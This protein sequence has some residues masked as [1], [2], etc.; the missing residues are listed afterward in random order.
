LF[1]SATEDAKKPEDETSG[2]NLELPSA[3]LLVVTLLLGTFF[4][5]SGGRSPDEASET[6]KLAEGVYARIVRPDGPAV[7]NAGFIVL[8][9]GVLVYDTHATPE[10]GQT[11]LSA[12]AA[13]TA[14]PVRYIVNS[15]FHP[16][17][18]HGNQAFG[19]S[20]LVVGGTN[21]RRD[22]LQKDVPAM[23]RSLNIAQ[24]QL[25]RMRRELVRERDRDQQA[26]LRNQIR[27][28]QE[29]VDRMSKIKVIPPILTLDDRL[30]LKDAAREIQV[31]QLGNGH[32]DGDVILF[33]AREK[34]AFL[35]DLFFNRA[36]PNTQDS[37]LLPWIA[38]LGAILKL[39]ADVFVPGHGP[40][41]NRDQ[42]KQFL[43]Y[44]EDLKASVEPRVSRGDSMEQVLHD[45]QVPAKYASF[46]FQNFFPANVQ[47]MYV[48]L[49]GLR[50]S[51]TPGSIPKAVKK[52]PDD[53]F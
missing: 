2:R 30:T 10:A 29:F 20:A 42:L 39:D 48:E 44:L 41:G 4:W 27:Q 25:A 24:S 52:A 17:H 1:R 7:S 36:L 35:G 12:I 6:A 40:V 53:R 34:I 18:T 3:A 38:T 51:Q 9:N 23:N 46:D 14:K 47:R 8:E 26:S 13:V 28:R 19:A 11:L 31:F 22:I 21:A 16:D 50:E 5:T 49:K 45:L 33:L 15:H 43:G 32:T 37:F